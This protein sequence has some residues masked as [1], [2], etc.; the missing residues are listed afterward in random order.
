[1]KKFILFLSVFVSISVFSQK[2]N[3]N[4]FKMVSEIRVEKIDISDEVYET[5]IYT[6]LYDNKERLTLLDCLI[7]DF[8]VFKNN[9]SIKHII[10][11]HTKD[12]IYRKDY[13]GS[14][15]NYNACKYRYDI[16]DGFILRSG[17]TYQAD[18]NGWITDIRDKY[19][20]ENG[21]LTGISRHW[22]GKYRNERNF[23]HSTERY[24]YSIEYVDGNPYSKNRNFERETYY[25]ELYDDTNININSLVWDKLGQISVTDD[26][27]ELCTEWIPFKSNNLIKCSGIGDNMNGKYNLISY[28]FDENG[29]IGTILVKSS[30]NE[31]IK[32]RIHLS[33]VY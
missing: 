26:Y 1:M 30:S 15:K 29:N 33:Y 14:D 28:E 22:F 8:S 6:L 19:S 10:I 9:P 11:K 16:E 27:I 20:Y 31:R 17:K 2:L 13:S 25:D 4:G 21:L 32:R 12:E 5:R 24:I 18:E 3:S 7:K 23:E